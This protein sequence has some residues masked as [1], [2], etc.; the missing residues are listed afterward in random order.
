MPES[1]DVV[2]HFARP[3]ADN[4]ARSDPC[5]LCD[6]GPLTDLPDPK[7]AIGRW[8]AGPLNDPDRRERDF[9]HVPRWSSTNVARSVTCPAC[10]AHPTV[11]ARRAASVDPKPLTD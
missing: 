5:R 3:N 2:M 11:V 10:L 1:D 8:M 4:P 7:R 9:C 6:G